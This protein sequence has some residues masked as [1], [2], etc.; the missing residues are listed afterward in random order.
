MAYKTLILDFDGTI[1]DTQQSIVQTMQ[2]VAASLHI[3]DVDEGLIKSLIGLPLK[4]T[5]EKAFSLNEE[6]IRV[7]TIK[8]RK[9]Y[10][11]IAINTISLFEGVQNTLEHFY[12]K[13]VHLHIASSKGREA[14]VKILQKQQVY[15]L[16][17]FV[18]GEEDVTQK[19]PSPEIV[20]LILNKYGYQSNECLVVGDT[21]F[22]IE[23]GQRAQV[24]TCGVTYG[25]NTRETLQKQN[26]D[27][28]IDRFSDLLEVV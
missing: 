21:V 14:L 8:Y 20:Q 16:F 27:Y 24:A 18:G 22:D 25:N 17:S 7:A 10:N 26:P 4:T 19:K 11:E 15:A 9:H 1:A 12:R 6:E 5:F 23:M 13:G 2:F 3:E 28:L